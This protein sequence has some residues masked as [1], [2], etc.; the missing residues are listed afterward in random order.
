MS[1]FDEILN[2]NLKRAVTYSELNNLTYKS[3]GGKRLENKNFYEGVTNP[4]TVDFTPPAISKITKDMILDY[5]QK[6]EEA[7]YKNAAGE[8]VK[9]QETGLKGDLIGYQPRFEGDDVDLEGAKRDLADMSKLLKMKEKESI[10]ITKELQNLYLNKNNL[11]NEFQYIP[12]NKLSGRTQNEVAKEV[13]ETEKKIKEFE[14]KIEDIYIEIMQ[15]KREVEGQQTRIKVVD[16]NIKDNEREKAIVDK[17]NKDIVR[18]YGEKFNYLNRN[19]IKAE[20]QPNESDEAYIQRLQELEKYK[21]DPNIYKQ[22]AINQNVNKLKINLKQIVKDDA[23]IEE[24]VADF[25]D[26]D[27]AYILNSYWDQISVY[28]KKY[29]FDVNNKDFDLLK[30]KDELKA[31]IQNIKTQPFSLNNVSNIVKSNDKKINVTKN[32]D[33]VLEL[34]NTANNKKLYIRIRKAKKIDNVEYSLDNTNYEVFNFRSDKNIAHSFKE[35]LQKFD[36]NLVPNT[37]DFKAIFGSKDKKDDIFKHLEGQ[38]AL[39]KSGTVAAGSGLK[40]GGGMQQIQENKE[41]EKFNEDIRSGER[42][43]KQENAGASSDAFDIPKVIN[44]GKNKLLLNKLYYNNILSVKD[45]KMHSIEALKNQHVSDQFVKVIYNIYNNISNNEANLS[46][47]ELELFHLLLFVSGLNKKK[48]IDIK[49][50]DHITKLKERLL[51]VESQINAGNDNPA[52]LEEM[53]QI[54][55]KLYLYKAISLPNAKLYIKQFNK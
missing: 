20:Q 16:A 30:L 5:R 47:K 33:N 28:L 18:E 44:F 21:V 14:K 42:Q 6:E 9:Y 55:S 41:I 53:K 4:G 27:D 29:G 10:K 31:A 1:V 36:S 54:I 46:D 39:T 40:I 35:T 32:G 51:L 15:I 25:R 37:A 2:E 24:I 22:K 23:K 50:A 48:N 8:D 3:V 17:T 52:V 13:V 43:R 45:S 26:G 7:T 19:Q 38:I 49:R 34:T 12:I 11:Y